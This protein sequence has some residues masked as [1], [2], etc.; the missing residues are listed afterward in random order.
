MINHNRQKDNRLFAVSLIV[1]I[2]FV[3]GYLLSKLPQSWV[4]G[5]NKDYSKN[6]VTPTYLISTEKLNKENKQ[7]I[8]ISAKLDPNGHSKQQMELQTQQQFFDGAKLLQIGHYQQAITV[9]HKVLTQYPNLPEVHINLGFAMLG[10]EESTKAVKSF[11]Y[12][13]ELKPDEANA[14]YGLALV[15]EKEQDYEIAMGAMRTYIHLR[16][17]DNYIAKARAALQFW[18]SEI[19]NQKTPQSKPEVIEN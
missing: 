13:L 12:A 4:I 18:Q 9:F 14:Y 3:G 2:V 19:N 11:N 5:D 6:A 7:P 8:A 10:L 15:A 16:Q 1:I 17:D